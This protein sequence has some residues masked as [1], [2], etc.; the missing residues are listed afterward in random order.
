V[1]LFQSSNLLGGSLGIVVF[2]NLSELDGLFVSLNVLEL[3]GSFDDIKK[4]VV[5]LS[6]FTRVY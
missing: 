1:R 3:K 4:V 5:W 2:E 6:E